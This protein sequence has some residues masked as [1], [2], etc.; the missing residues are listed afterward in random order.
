MSEQ[1]AKEFD[2]IWKH[3]GPLPVVETSVRFKGKPLQKDGVFA[4][5]RNGRA[6]RV[7]AVS[8]GTE[9]PGTFR[10]VPKDVVHTFDEKPLSEEKLTQL[11]MQCEFDDRD[12][13]KY[14][15]LP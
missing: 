7:S 3:D 14:L 15:I 12:E 10:H 5:L 6:F 11:R 8:K 13:W 9:E 1:L 2:Y 4:D